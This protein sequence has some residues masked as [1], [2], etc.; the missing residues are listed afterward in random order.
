M[1]VAKVT[2]LR[3]AT[4]LVAS[5]VPQTAFAQD[6]SGLDEAG[7][8]GSSVARTEVTPYIEVAQVLTT[9]LSPGDD[10]V[11]YSRVAAGVE[12]NIVGN[13]TAGGVSLRYERRIGYGDD[14]VQ[15]D[16]LSG[17]ARVSAEVVPQTVTVDAGALA[18]R[19]RFDRGNVSPLVT[20]DDS[21]TSTVYSVYAG[22]SVS[23]RAGD[24]AVNAGYRAGYTRVDSNDAVAIRPGSDP[25]DAFDESIVQ[26]AQLSAGTRAGEVLPV[27]VTAAA[28]FFQEDISNLDQR[29]RDLYGRVDVTVPITRDVALMGGVGYENVELS[30]RDAVRDASGAAVIGNDGRYVT[31]GTAPRRIAYEAD[32]IIWD[33]GVMWRPSN[34]TALEAHVGRRYGS[35]TYYGS[36]GYRPNQRLSINVSAYDNVTGFGGQITNALDNLPTSF[37]AIRNPVTGDLDN[38]VASEEGGNCLS[39]VL[40]SVRSSLF[41][42]RGVQ[43][44]AT[45]QLGRISTGIGAGYDR[46][47][48]YAAQGTV[49]EAADGLTDETY[50]VNAFVGAQLDRRSSFSGT[51]YANWFE[52]GL[53]PLNDATIYG[54]NGI[55][56]RN[57]LD[58]LEGSVAVSLDGITR[59]QLEDYWTA[60]AQLGLRYSF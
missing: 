16:Y 26:S 53:S 25:I 44:S 45:E 2:T 15:G 49:L 17:V 30:S 54:A 46:R 31:D 35:T 12:A 32:G 29:A 34:R 48:F 41:R 1:I 20:Q 47:R 33:A 5:A 18:T 22:P 36:F 3:L 23:T 55:Y 11:T 4:L 56:A 10:T 28:G 57:I 59:D 60:S 42:G 37:R 21:Q 27:G 19:S 39:G 24:V 58:A 51:I 43:V 8:R 6:S 52:S 7:T 9:E 50:W 13:R 14:K 40:G 38:C